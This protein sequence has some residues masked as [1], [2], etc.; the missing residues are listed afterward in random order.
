MCV[1]IYI[2]FKKQQYADIKYLI[3][4]HPAPCIPTPEDV[5]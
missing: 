3:P 1:R 5:G 2:R 4:A